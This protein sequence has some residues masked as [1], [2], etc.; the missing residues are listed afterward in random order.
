MSTS[1]ASIATSTTSGTAGDVNVRVVPFAGKK[2]EWENWKEKF[3][4]RAAIDKYDGIINGDDVLP[5]THDETGKKL[6]L[7]PDEVTIVDLNKK[8]FGHLN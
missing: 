8:G 7:K 4:I 5:E 6:T 1:G 3:M 2:E